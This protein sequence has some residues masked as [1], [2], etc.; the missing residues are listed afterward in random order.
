MI[1]TWVTLFLG[2][3]LST[4]GC[5]L[6]SETMKL[7]ESDSGKTVEIEVGDDLEVV[8]PAN[9]TTGYVW[10]VSSLDS[11]VVS[12][13]NSE[14]VANDNAIGS[15]G[16]DLIKFHAVGKGTSAVR[17]IFHRPFEVNKPPIKTFLMTVIIK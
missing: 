17:M 10:E 5:T 2:L 9:P 11:T 15:G 1:K 14:F 13:I 6:A 3:M 16:V 7:K 4:A 12:L 8:L